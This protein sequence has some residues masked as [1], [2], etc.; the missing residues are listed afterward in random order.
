MSSFGIITTG[1]FTDVMLEIVESTFIANGQD[2]KGLFSMNLADVYIS[3]CL[4]DSNEGRYS[5]IILHIKT[6][7]GSLNIEDSNFTYNEVTTSA[8]SFSQGSTGNV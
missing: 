1:D 8:F 3:R 5:V 4:F 2:Q 7:G 6:A